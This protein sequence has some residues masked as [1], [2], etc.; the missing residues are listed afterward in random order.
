[1]DK[2]ERTMDTLQAANA[3]Q[4]SGFTREQAEAIVRSHQSQD[5]SVATKAFVH[6][7]IAAAKLEIIKW[8]VGAVFAAAGL[9]AAFLKVA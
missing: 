4:A 5:D 1:M 2:T 3:L 6:A 8:N 7:E 9:V